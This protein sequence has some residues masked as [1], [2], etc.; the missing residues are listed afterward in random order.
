MAIMTLTLG[1]C[2]I[3]SVQTYMEM[4]KSLRSCLTVQVAS[5]LI[6]GDVC[7][8]TFPSVWNDNWHKIH[9]QIVAHPLAFN[10]QNI[11]S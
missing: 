3:V 9:I 10:H 1:M 7:I 5:S 4:S 8:L 11:M 6:C 2:D